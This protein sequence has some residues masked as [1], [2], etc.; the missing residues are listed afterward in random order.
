MTREYRPWRDAN[1]PF[2]P[3]L[4]LVRS[5]NDRLGL[6]ARWTFGRPGTAVADKGCC[7]NL[8]FGQSELCLSVTGGQDGWRSEISGGPGYL[9]LYGESDVVGQGYLPCAES[10]TRT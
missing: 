8:L 5:S 4:N 9:N 10:C 3:E 2:L 7:H 6:L 1:I